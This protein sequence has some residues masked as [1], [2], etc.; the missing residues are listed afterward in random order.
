MLFSFFMT[1]SQNKLKSKKFLIL[2]MIVTAFISRFIILGEKIDISISWP[3][4]F[5][6]YIV[7]ANF[8]W[9]LYYFFISKKSNIFC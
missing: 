6:T 1:K 7:Y 3:L 4:L 9:L 2:G 8:E 5:K